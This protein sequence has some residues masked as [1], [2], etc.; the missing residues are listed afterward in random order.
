MITVPIETHP[1]EFA[2][3]IHSKAIIATSNSKLLENK[4]RK[5]Q[6]LEEIQK[7]DR[8]ENEVNGI[9]NDLSV[10]LKAIEVLSLQV[11]MSIKPVDYQTITTG[12]AC[13]TN[14]RI[15]ES[16]YGGEYFIPSVGKI[17]EDNKY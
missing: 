14:F 16:I 7:I 17:T 5:K 3:D 12:G 1:N 15:T 2:R 8:L 11:Q 10:L 4:K 6:K 9:R 13:P